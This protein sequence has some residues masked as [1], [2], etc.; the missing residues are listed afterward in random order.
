MPIGKYKK[1]EIRKLAENYNLPTMARRDSQ[2]ICFLG[3]IKFKE[4]IKH[5][6]GEIEGDIVDIDT[7]KILGKAFWLLLLYNWAEIR[8]KTWWRSLVCCEE[9]CEEQPHLYFEAR[10]C[11]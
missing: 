2:G 3:Q 5:H 1:S 4:F 8:A 7:G 9:R 6:L 10:R 11:H